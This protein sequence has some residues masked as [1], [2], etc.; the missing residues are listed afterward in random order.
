MKSA[1]VTL[2]ASALLIIPASQATAGLTNMQSQ[3]VAQN[4]TSML[5]VPNRFAITD[6]AVSLELK[7]LCYLKH[8]NLMDKPAV[9]IVERCW[10]A[11]GHLMG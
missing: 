9:R 4:D 2:I 8:M 11:H 5:A 7:R 1:F 3:L 10:A 6:G